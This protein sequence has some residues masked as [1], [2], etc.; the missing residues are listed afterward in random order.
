MNRKIIPNY[1]LYE[2]FPYNTPE[3]MNLQNHP[4]NQSWGG[5]GFLSLYATLLAIGEPAP[6]GL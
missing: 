2:N 1:R 5:G 4:P 3:T 6:T